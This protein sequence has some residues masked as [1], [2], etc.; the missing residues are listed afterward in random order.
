MISKACKYGIRAAVF[1][2]SQADKNQKLNVKEI[3]REVDA[4]EAFTAKILQVLNKHRIITSLKGPYGGFYIE[5]FQ[6]EQP[7]I[8]IVN[9]IDGMAVFHE[10][11]L[12]LKRCAEL[13]PCPMHDKFKAARETL[14]Q[15]FQETTI[16]Q[17]ASALQEGTSFINNLS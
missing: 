12:G 1:V 5:D 13:H 14:R 10:C 6:L 9:A 17:L 3:A 7:V 4:P 16:R 15:V 11:G 8:N 2:A